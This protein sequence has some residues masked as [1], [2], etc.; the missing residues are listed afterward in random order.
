M[1][2]LVVDLPQTPST[3]GQF[4]H[5]TFCTGGGGVKRLRYDVSKASFPCSFYV[6][7]WGDF[8]C[9]SAK[10]GCVYNFH[11]TFFGHFF[12]P[13]MQTKKL[14]KGCAL[15]VYRVCFSGCF[16][17]CSCVAI[18][19][20]ILR[21]WLLVWGFSACF[22]VA[23]FGHGQIARLCCSGLLAPYANVRSSV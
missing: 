3:L 7:M 21:F 18:L 16:H 9:E 22:L 12:S 10:V 13:K 14:A 6:S 4:P 5:Q 19:N 11:F 2:V 8:V 17:A 15:S 20:S 23:V 1:D